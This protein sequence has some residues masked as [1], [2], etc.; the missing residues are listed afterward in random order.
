[1]KNLLFYLILFAVVAL[2]VFGAQSSEFT[3]TWMFGDDVAGDSLIILSDVITVSGE[4]LKGGKITGVEIFGVVDS[5]TYQIIL[6]GVPIGGAASSWAHDTLTLFYTPDNLNLTI[7][8]IRAVTV[9]FSRTSNDT[10]TFLVRGD[11][12]RYREN[13][14]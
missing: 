13:W 14:R 12:L 6:G 9:W 5:M 1:M 3:K 8:N 2:V 4:A 10:L 11:R 7:E